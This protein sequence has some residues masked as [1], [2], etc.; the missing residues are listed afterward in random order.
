LHHPCKP[1]SYKAAKGF[2]QRLSSGSVRC[3]QFFKEA[4]H[5]YVEK[6]GEENV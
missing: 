2:E 3:P 5:N 1:L 6:R 4:I